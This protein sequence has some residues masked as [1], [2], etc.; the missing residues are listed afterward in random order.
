MI[1]AP[2]GTPGL[3]GGT[4]DGA[5][6]RRVVS[7]QDMY[8]TIVDLCGLPPRRDIDGRSLVP[9]LH[10]PET[11][12]NHP[13]ISSYDFSEFS[14]RTQRWRY[15]RLIDGSEELY[16]HDKDPEEW[17]NLANHPQLKQI[18][19]K[20][21]RHIPRNPAPLKQTSE[22]LSLHHFPPF[23]SRAEYEDWLKHG[24]DTRYLIKTYW[25]QD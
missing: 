21:A 18:K 2:R 17:T 24:K 16:D 19:A 10:N 6:C 25:L 20:L 1:K 23:R 11:Q 15:T 22:K 14:I 12:W 13:A 7:L 5:V 3:P 9:L 4:K 8:P